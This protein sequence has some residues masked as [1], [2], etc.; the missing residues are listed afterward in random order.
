[1]KAKKFLAAGLTLTMLLGAVGGLTAC[2]EAPHSHSL[3]TVAKKEATCT[4]AGYEAYYKCSGCDLI[5]SDDK[6]ET[7]IT[8]PKEISAG[9]KVEAVAKKDATCTAVGAAAHYKCTVCNKLF[10]DAEGKTVITAAATIPVTEHTIEAVSQKRPTCTEDGYE[11]HFKCSECNTLFADE[12]GTTVIEAATAIPAKHRIEPVAQKNANC[13]EDG[14]EAHFKCTLCPKLFSDENGTQEITAPVVI[15][16]T[17]EHTIGFGFTNETAPAPVAAGGT[18]STKCLVCGQAADTITYDTGFSMNGVTNA[19]A[20]KMES[21]GNYYITLGA[22]GN[23][24]SRFGFHATKAGT[25]KLTFTDV[26][27]QNETLTRAFSGIWITEN[28]YTTSSTNNLWSGIKKDWATTTNLQETINKYKDKIV[29]EEV[30]IEGRASLISITFTL[31]EEDIPEGGIYI[32]LMLT[33]KV[34]NDQGSSANPTEPSTYLIRYEAPAA[35]TEEG[36]QE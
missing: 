23:T 31:T 25:Y 18:L 20:L 13:L 32:T 34:I 22:S 28:A 36:T 19:T 26:F 2:E 17:T 7:E 21:A 27:A 4:E 24:Y 35:E 30:T 15:P 12:E 3:E 16:Q 10:S 5:F 14:Y 1:M 29:R 6:G 11:E 9:H 33:D 8:A